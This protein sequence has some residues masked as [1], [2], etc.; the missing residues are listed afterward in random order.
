MAIVFGWML[1]WRSSGRASLVNVDMAETLCEGILGSS[2][3]LNGRQWKMDFVGNGI[4]GSW[5]VPQ[6]AS[7][8]CRVVMGEI[9]KRD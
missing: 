8:N 7:V 4:S 5:R 6:R 2:R 9:K 3:Y 1:L